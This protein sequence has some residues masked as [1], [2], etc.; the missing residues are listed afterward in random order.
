[1]GRWV[2]GSMGRRSMCRWIDGTM[3]RWINDTVDGSMGR[4]VDESMSRWIDGLMN[5]CRE[6]IE[7]NFCKQRNLQGLMGQ[8]V[9]GL[10][11]D[12]NMIFLEAP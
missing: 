8:R 2:D 10:M 7:N 5:R 4:W 3:G 9:D 11:D 6:S 12:F 1:M